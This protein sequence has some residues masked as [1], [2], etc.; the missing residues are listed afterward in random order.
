VLDDYQSAPIAEGLRATLGFLDTMTRRPEALTADDARAVLA[1]GVSREALAE[2]V[3]VAYLRSPGGHPGLGCPTGG[4][5]IVRG[6]GAESVAA[7]LPL[8]Q[9]VR[10]ELAAA[11]G[12]GD[13]P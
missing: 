11:P 6:R 12:L 13:G 5:W 4:R 3:H 8:N 9:P 2:A 10:R 7:G 1:A